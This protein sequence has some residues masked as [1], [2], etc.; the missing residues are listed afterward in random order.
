VDRAQEFFDKGY[1]VAQADD[2][3][4]LLALRDAVHRA[5]QAPLP[6]TSADVAT[7]FDGFHRHDM[8]G[9][10]LNEY[11]MKVIAG[12]NGALDC[13]AVIHSAF[14][15]I[16]LELV[17]PDVVVQKSTN[18]V[19]AQP[20]DTSVSP[21]HRDAPPNS[22]YEVVVWIP[23]TD[24]YGTKG[25]KVLDKNGSA[26]ALRHLGGPDGD[27]AR[28]QDYAWQHG[29]EVSAPFGTALFFW[30]GLV[31]AVPVNAENETRWSLNIRYKSLYSPYGN[32]GFPDF[33]KILHL[34]PLTRLGM[35]IE[36]QER[37]LS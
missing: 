32:K 16:L 12:F 34:S 4:P 3:G 1:F 22:P 30:T 29:Q 17:G 10:A 31:H 36:G 9:S 27:Y 25:M 24:C 33:F 5:A 37:G 15:Q 2:M 20:G 21:V 19:I 35:A 13:G 6:A 8:T 11:R 28:F 18:L 23:L 14:R 26:E 7:F